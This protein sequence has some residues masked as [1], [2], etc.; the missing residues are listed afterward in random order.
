MIRL[1]DTK[2]A[3]TSSFLNHAIRIAEFYGFAPLDDMSRQSL[4]INRNK[5]KSKGDSDLT[6]TRR[7]ERSLPSG[8]RKCIACVPVKVNAENVQTREP[9]LAW[10]ISGG[11][12]QMPS[13]GLEL[14]I[15]GTSSA[16][17][18]ALLIVV[19]HAITEE[20]G[21]KQRV[22]CV[23]NIGSYESSNRYVRDVGVY[24][25]KHIESISPTLRPRIVDDPMGTLVQ[26]IEKGHPAIPRAPQAMEYLTEEERRRFWELLEYL[27]VF[28]LP[29][30]LNAQVLGSRDLWAHSLYEISGVDEET[31][32][33]IALAFGGRTDPIATRLAG[34]TTSAA[35][36]TISC[37]VRGST[38]V[39]QEARGLPGIYFAH[40]GGEARRRSL[41]VMESLRAAAIP[42]HHGLCYD[43]IGEQMAAARNLAVPY[44]LIMGHKEA[45][46]GTVL[47]RE[48]AT[49]SQQA[50]PVPDLPNYIKRHRMSNWKIP[51]KA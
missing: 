18:E 12:A 23:N 15:L 28:G 22:L 26:L 21:I 9:L 4:N 46:E 49:N 1:K 19:A 16:L 34:R 41:G 47:V 14:H 27:E 29:Y 33:R 45:M 31:G 32:V 38:R 2:H 36:I 11:T 25:R 48:V 5:S 39:K 37:E 10:R 3:T 50:V 40:L 35:M 30:E 42:V 6:F 51:E 7:D 20:A 44:V 24:L 8:M 17:A 43:K 13:K